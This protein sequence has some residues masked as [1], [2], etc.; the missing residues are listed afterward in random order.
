MKVGD[1]KIKRGFLVNKNDVLVEKEVNT[2]K[3]VRF[4]NWER[5]NIF[6]QLIQI[7]DLLSKRGEK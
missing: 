4:D 6:S 5:A 7:K 2:E 3:F 1:I